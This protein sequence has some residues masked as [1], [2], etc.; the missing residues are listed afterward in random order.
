MRVVL[1]LNDSFD[2]STTPC[3][4][5][6]G[7]VTCGTASA[8]SGTTPRSRRHGLRQAAHVGSIERTVN[9]GYVVGDEDL[10]SVAGTDS[11]ACSR[12][13]YVTGC[14]VSDSVSNIVAVAASPVCDIVVRFRSWSGSERQL[15]VVGDVKPPS[16]IYCQ[17][18]L[19]RQTLLL[20]GS[21][22]AP[23]RPFRTLF[24][25]VWANVR[26]I[27]FVS[28]RTCVRNAFGIFPNVKR[29]CKHL[30]A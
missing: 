2:G 11:M 24:P 23:P 28:I 18:S 15:V 21:H 14:D 25:K 1:Q 19:H 26:N 8:M 30:N 3:S 12:C 5:I 7:S 13:S 6:P 17:H 9:G 29:T 16:L 27:L 10:F 20:V 4:S 22:A